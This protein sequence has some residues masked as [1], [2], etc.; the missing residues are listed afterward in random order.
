MRFKDYLTEST[1][2]NIHIE[3]VEDH[4]FQG[5]SG[6]NHAVEALHAV[7]NRIQ[8]KPSQA[9]ITTKFDGTPA[10][11][12]GHH[13][14]K[15][16]VVTKS[17]FNKKQKLM[18]TESDIDR[19]YGDKPELKFALKS[20]LNQLKKVAPEKGIFQGDLMYT[21]RNKHEDDTHFHFT[22]NTI[23]YSTKKDE[24]EGKKIKSAKLGIVV[25]TRYHGHDLQS[26]QASS[27]V[28]LGTFKKD[29]EV[30]IINP[31]LNVKSPIRD[32]ETQTKFSKFIHEAK[33]EIDSAPPGIFD[34][35]R[36]HSAHLRSYINQTVRNDEKPTAQ[37]FKAYM[38]RAF[39]KE[40]ELLRSVAGKTKKQS[41]L[42]NHLQHVDDNHDHYQALINAH[43]NLH[44]AKETLLSA[45]KKDGEY[46]TSI[47]GKESDHEG[48]VVHLNGVMS[49][50]VKR[51]E[52]SK[53]NFEKHDKKA[54]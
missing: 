29:K 14:G 9:K 6:F 23:M 30:H 33:K 37:G 50:L 48:Y 34:A 52:F 42:I 26:L 28:G 31:E 51:G 13:E 5:H 38:T 46:E 4:T 7:N 19:E 11:V 25:H 1:G 47:G 8:G 12:F 54:A 39:K 43:R 27:D 49:K 15:F 44:M 16:F 45:M 20:A 41:Q 22:P 17:V 32:E 21:S 53:A 10:I 36:I 18:Y 40:I 3:H 2:H 35:T 24:P